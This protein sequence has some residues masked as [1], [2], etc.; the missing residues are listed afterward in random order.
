[1]RDRRAH[2]Q[3]DW[4]VRPLHDK[5]VMPFHERLR[6]HRTAVKLSQVRVGQLVAERM[7]RAS[8][9]SQSAVDRWETADP[10]RKR[11]P[12]VQAVEAL[13]KVFRCPV[14]E[15]LGDTTDEVWRIE[16]SVFCAYAQLVLD[17]LRYAPTHTSALELIVEHPGGQV[18][19]LR[20][21]V[22]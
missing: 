11:L 19:R 21:E 10:T 18:T 9:F 6:S 13:A 3:G 7:G 16:A 2:C 22:D 17:A 20:W 8:P 5:M 4:L 12:S 15:L 1:M 14:L